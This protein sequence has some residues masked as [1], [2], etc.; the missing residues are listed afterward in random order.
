MIGRQL[1]DLRRV[2]AA[3]LVTAAL[4]LSS[5]AALAETYVF[6]KAHTE[7]RF[8]WSHFGLSR[9]SGMILDYDGELVFDDASPENSKLEITAK[10]DSLWTHVDKLTQH[11]KAD[12]FFNVAQHPDISFRTTKVEKTGETTGKIT[13]DLTIK[14]VT[15]TVTFDTELNFKGAHPFSQKPTLGFSATTTV[16]RSDFELGKFVPAIPD[17]ILITIETELNE[18]SSVEKTQG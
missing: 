12:D 14:G 8:S 1:S 16:K 13:G 17:E 5:T 18:K 7:I 4:A 2:A 6:D 15:R 9:M 10:T 11:L 3:G